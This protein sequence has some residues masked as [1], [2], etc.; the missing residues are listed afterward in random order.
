M[1][2]KKVVNPFYY[3]VRGKTFGSLDLMV[4]FHCT[5]ILKIYELQQFDLKLTK[6][7]KCIQIIYHD[8]LNIFWERNE[9]RVRAR[10]KKNKD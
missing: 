8:R 7:S 3:M 6:I 5:Q 9:D 4:F 10:E 2:L 1:Q